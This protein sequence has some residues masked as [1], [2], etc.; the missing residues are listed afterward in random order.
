MLERS[1]PPN[2]KLTHYQNLGELLLVHQQAL[3]RA[4]W[5][6]RERGVRGREHRKRASTTQG[7]HQPS[8]LYR[9]H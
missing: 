2:F 4:R 3:N 9:R 7:L 8:G 1:N 5:Q 6:F